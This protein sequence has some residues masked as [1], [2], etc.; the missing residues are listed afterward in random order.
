[1]E[2]FFDAS[3]FFSLSASSNSL[4]SLSKGTVFL[5][6]VMSQ[7][8]PLISGIRRMKSD[9]LFSY[10]PPFNLMAFAILWPAS[11][12]LSPRSLHTAN[13]FLIRLTVRLCPYYVH[14]T[15]SS[16]DIPNR[17]EF[18]HPDRH[19]PLRTIFPTRHTSPR[20]HETCQH[21]QPRPSPYYDIGG[22]VF[23]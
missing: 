9:A 10:Q 7:R 4:S 19:L 17:L 18:P 21:N 8:T 15:P 1:M 11:F 14:I 5:L 20:P 22:S 6:P 2:L 13:V 3:L 16:L 23:V 12:I